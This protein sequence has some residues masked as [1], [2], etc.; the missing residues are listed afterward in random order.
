MIRRSLRRIALCILLFVGF[1]LLSGCI[2]VQVR[3]PTADEPIPSV[4]DDSG[5][6]MGV[7]LNNATDYRKLIGDARS[8]KPIRPGAVNKT[9]ALKQL[10]GPWM[11][12]PDGRSVAYVYIV[13]KS[14]IVFPLCGFATGP[15]ASRAYGF[16]LDFD[17]ANLLT[18]V[19]ME[20]EDDSDSYLLEEIFEPPKI[21]EF[22]N[23]RELAQK[24][25][26]PIKD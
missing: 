4:W 3:I 23:L 8:D 16:R 5:A 9:D 24:L 18:D 25:G 10:G 17:Q 2:Y 21:W 1:A 19:K 11:T 12:S 14:R 7:R 20:T 13:K 6:N 22:H 15:G 26:M